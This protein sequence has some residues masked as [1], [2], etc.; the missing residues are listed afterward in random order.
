[1]GDLNLTSGSGIR[2]GPGVRVD[3]GKDRWRENSLPDRLTSRSIAGARGLR[4]EGGQVC[5]RGL[6]GAR[7]EEPRGLLCHVRMRR[8]SRDG[9]HPP[10][11]AHDLSIGATLPILRPAPPMDPLTLKVLLPC[12]LQD[13]YTAVAG[14]KKG[15]AENSPADRCHRLI[16]GR[17]GA[18]LRF[19]PAG[20]E[21][22]DGKE[23]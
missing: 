6:Q 5:Q 15:K 16:E 17:G 23:T 18:D 4:P 12:L 20:K 21:G 13:H 10:R 19:A 7:G 3:V 11:S 14:I 2:C 9:A 22:K 8:G 1:M